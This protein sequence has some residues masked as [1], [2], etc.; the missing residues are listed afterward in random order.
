MKTLQNSLSTNRLRHGAGQFP[1]I[2]VDDALELRA[3]QGTELIRQGLPQRRPGLAFPEPSQVPL[4]VHGVDRL[5]PRNTSPNERLEPFVHQDRDR[6]TLC[7][8][9]VFEKVQALGE[10]THSCKL[11]DK[12]T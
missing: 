2:Q 9:Q 11:R 8:Y 4:Q 3:P 7:L 10:I 5:E 1:V 6:V 12:N